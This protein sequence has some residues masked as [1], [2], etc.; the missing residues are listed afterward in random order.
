MDFNCRSANVQPKR[1]K[2]MTRTTAHIKECWVTKSK[3]VGSDY[4][5]KQ[6]KAGEIEL[7][8]N[9]LQDPAPHEQ[10]NAVS[11]TIIEEEGPSN[12]AWE[13]HLSKKTRKLLKQLQKEPRVKWEDAITP[14]V[15]NPPPRPKTFYKKK[16]KN[17]SQKG[18]KPV[19]PVEL[20]ELLELQKHI[21]MLEEHKQ[22]TPLPA[23][24]LDF[25][26]EEVLEA[27]QLYPNS[28]S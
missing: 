28:A 25:L 12:A 3:T 27:P 19:K 13:I 2:L 17:G 21:Q 1:Q 5:E 6:I 9:A 7:T 20:P 8:E 26:T 22:G 10:A 4:V 23:I 14:V 11:H 15:H 24:L 18:K 16:N